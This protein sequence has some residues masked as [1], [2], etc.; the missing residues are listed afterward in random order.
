MRVART[1]TA[2]NSFSVHWRLASASSQLR[3]RDEAAV[4][5]PKAGS[6]ARGVQLILERIDSGQGVEPI[7]V[8]GKNDRE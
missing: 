6:E 7:K 8:D 2:H 1:A 4:D 5:T 3:H